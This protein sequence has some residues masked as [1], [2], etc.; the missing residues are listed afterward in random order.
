M[1]LTG[2]KIQ[3][4]V[5]KN[6]I[7]INPFNLNRI[8]TNSYDL[9]LGKNLIQYTSK[10]LD[11]KKKA[12]FKKIV[13][14]EKG[15]LMKPGTFLLGETTEKIGSNFYVPIIHAK[16]GIA[17]MGLFVHVTANLID[18]GSYGKSTL[19]LFSTLPIK[20]YPG[21]LIAQVSFWKPKGKIVL[22][23]GKYQ[24]SDGPRPSLAYKDFK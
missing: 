16:S 1:I 17:R 19:Q 5:G 6:K 4:E 2:N 9:R 23:N 3:K 18:I 8:T 10:T 12:N 22:Y 21:M 14:F 11:P 24:N 20:L 15:Y 13:I 7:R